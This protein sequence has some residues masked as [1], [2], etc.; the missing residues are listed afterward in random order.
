MSR[1]NP[2]TNRPPNVRIPGQVDN[3]FKNLKGMQGRVGGTKETFS[4]NSKVFKFS[5]FEE[6]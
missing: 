4:A 3:F 6:N 2:A 1:Y 5:R